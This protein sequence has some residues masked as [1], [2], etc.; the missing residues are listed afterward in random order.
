MIEQDQELQAKHQKQQLPKNNHCQRCAKPASLCICDSLAPVKTKI[1]VLVLQHPQEPDVALGSGKLTALNLSNSQ[2]KIGLSWRSLS[3][4]LGF[5]ANPKEWAVLYLGSARVNMQG[6]AIVLVDKEGKELEL[7]Q[8]ILKSIKGLILLDGTWSQA[9]TL[10]WR[11]AWLLKLRR[12]IL[13]PAGPSLYGK[14]RKEPRPD[15]V[16]TIESAAL[17][18]SI[19]EGQAGLEEEILRPFK[20]LLSLYVPTATNRPKR[21]VD[22]RRRRPKASQAKRS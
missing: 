21:K 6:P 14:F 4:A 10:W 2:I 13:V 11:N 3:H 9:K 18:I 1:K 15:S 22:W 12:A 8:A 7:Q 17:A 19:L 5:E 16:S 20:K